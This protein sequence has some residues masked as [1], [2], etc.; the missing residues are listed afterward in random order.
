MG[1][2]QTPNFG[3][4]HVDSLPWRTP[5]LLLTLVN[6]DL[7]REGR[8]GMDAWTGLTTSDDK[9]RKTDGCRQDEFD[10]KRPQLNRSDESKR[11][12]KVP[13]QRDESNQKVKRQQNG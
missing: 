3:R 2:G 5:D 11:R 13:N 4:T 9:R 6:L 12:I 7:R 1:H 8:V 10:G